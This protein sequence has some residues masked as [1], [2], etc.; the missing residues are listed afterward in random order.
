[1]SSDEDDEV[2]VPFA[3]R[4]EW[5]DVIPIAQNESANP[6]VRIPYSPQYAEVGRRCKLD[7]G[8][9]APPGFKP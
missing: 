8:L 7:P 6:V 4:P 1:M 9:K 5:Q 3:D 2:N